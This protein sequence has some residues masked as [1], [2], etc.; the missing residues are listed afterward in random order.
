[1]AQQ[2]LHD[3]PR[4]VKVADETSARDLGR[5][6]REFL[7]GFL[8]TQ[9]APNPEE[10]PF[11]AA[12]IDTFLSHFVLAVQ[13]HSG[14]LAD[15]LLTL[16]LPAAIQT[17]ARSDSFIYEGRQ[18]A[19]SRRL[20]LPDASTLPGQLTEDLFL[21]RPQGFFEA[22]KECVWLQILNLAAS[23]DTSV[24]RIR[25]IIGETF[26]REYEDL[27]EPSV[28]VAQSL[29]GS[30]FP[31]RLFFSPNAVIETPVGT[32][33][34]RPKALVGPRITAFPP[35][36]SYPNLVESVPLDSVEALRQ[37]GGPRATENLDASAS[38]LGLAHPIDALVNVGT[39]GFA[40][41]ER[42]IG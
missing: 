19:H 15:Q 22:G 29:N 42:I 21:A 12:G 23:A 35:V 30:G 16:S 5:A 1:V 41:V 14:D 26:K 38:V 27:F 18:A 10:S 6:F 31:A 28:G 11:P 4:E 8:G 40:A 17:V 36:G 2:A 34:T 13:F 7:T 25:I 20:P 32:F 3:P 37:A 9:G 24:G 39:E 33:K